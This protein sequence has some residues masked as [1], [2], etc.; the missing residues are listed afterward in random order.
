MIFSTQA[1][2]VNC[3]EDSGRRPDRP[4][5]LILRGMGEVLFYMN[6]EMPDMN[7]VEVTQRQR[8]I[9]RRRSVEGQEIL[10]TT[11]SGMVRM[12]TASLKYIVSTAP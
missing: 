7:G 12:R 8:A 6:I 2:R 3:T 4:L 9:S 10:L 11:N 5:L 1:L